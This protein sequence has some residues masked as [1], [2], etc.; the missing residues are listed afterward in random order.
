MDD[1]ERAAEGGLP[2]AGDR[3]RGPVGQITMRQVLAA[4][5]EQALVVTVA[6]DADFLQMAERMCERPGL[7]TVAVVDENRRLVGIVPMRLL[8]DELFLQVVPEEFL[9]DVRSDI[10]ELGRLSR[11]RTARELM[12][13][14]VYVTLDETVRDAFVKMHANNLVG[15]PVVDEDGRLVGYVDGF[16]LMQVWLRGQSPEE[17]P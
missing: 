4:L 5:G 1:A 13:P 3:G 7:F 8:L 12:I 11:A 16:Q 17:R 10:T 2:E 9:K 14:P 6:E 15:V